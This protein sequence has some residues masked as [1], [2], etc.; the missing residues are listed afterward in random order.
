MLLDTGAQRSITGHIVSGGVAGL[1]LASYTNYQQ[2]KEGTI[3]QDK[4][5]KNTLVAGAQ[6]AIVTACAIGVS[7]ALGSNNKGGFQAVLESSAY[8]LAG[9]AG[10]YLISNLNEDK[11]IKE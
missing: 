6:G 3:S 7:N 1:L 2:Y 4:A 9:A 11:K 8:L 10:A 5:I